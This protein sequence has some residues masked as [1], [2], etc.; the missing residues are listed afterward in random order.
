[1]SPGIRSCIALFTPQSPVFRTVP[2]RSGP[3]IGP[4]RPSVSLSR[5]T[6]L[7]S[8]A[9]LVRP[10]VADF[11]SRAPPRSL[12]CFRYNSLARL[13]AFLLCSRG[14][15]GLHRP[16]ELTLRAPQSSRADILPRRQLLKHAIRSRRCKPPSDRSCRQNCSS[17]SYP[18]PPGRPFLPRRS[19]AEVGGP[20]LRSSSKV[21]YRCRPSRLRG[22]TSRVLADGQR[23]GL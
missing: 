10:P 20:S 8:L 3:P 15:R 17:T 13:F 11:W 21:T 1:M 16:G 2:E 6:A 22:R 19:C 4:C 9:A 5:P 14:D 18:H 12:V 7:L 23:P